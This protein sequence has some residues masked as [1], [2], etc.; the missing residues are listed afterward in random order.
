MGNALNEDITGRHVVLR[1]DSL[2]SEYADITW[3]VFHAQGGFGCS[4]DT[5]GNA[6]FGTFVRDGEEVRMQGY[7]V[8]RF[9]TDAEVE[10][11]RAAG[12]RS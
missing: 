11:A 12:G 9:A 4:P 3:R 8:E 2:K 10:A 7:H 6:M 5:A 1:E